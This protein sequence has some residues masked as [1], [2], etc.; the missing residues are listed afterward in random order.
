VQRSLQSIGQQGMTS[1][2]YQV[3]VH[4]YTA[5]SDATLYFTNCSHASP[6]RR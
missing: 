4:V 6:S 2:V 1:H 5:G 3:W